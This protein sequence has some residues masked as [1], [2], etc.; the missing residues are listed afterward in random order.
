LTPENHSGAGID[1]KKK[2]S[3]QSNNAS[4]TRHHPFVDLLLGAISLAATEAVFV[5]LKSAEYADDYRFF[6]RPALS[7]SLIES[8][9][10]A[11]VRLLLA[12]ESWV[13]RAG[14]LASHFNSEP[15]A[16]GGLH[17]KFTASPE[18]SS[19]AQ[20]SPSPPRC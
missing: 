5:A 12:A 9:T 14:R 17:L 1:K 16:A 15:C 11:A 2:D 3:E 10:E 13:P 18:T 20:H 4:P 6:R 19:I 8:C 7:R